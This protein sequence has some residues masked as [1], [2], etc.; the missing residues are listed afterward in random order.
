M[1]LKLLLSCLWMF[2]ITSVF[3]KQIDEKTALQIGRNFLSANASSQ[4]LKSASNLRVTYRLTSNSIATNSQ[5]TLYYVLK[6]GSSGF[7]IV[8]GDDNVSPIL[9]YSDEGAF[10][11]DSIPANAAKWFEGY[12]N[13]I[14]Y[15]IANNIDASPEIQEEWQALQSGVSIKSQALVSLVSPL[16][17]T[18]WN[19]SPY[20][21]AM[22]PGGSVTGCVATA[23]AQ[24]MKYWQYPEKG[25]GF[26]SYRHQRYGTLSAN[27]GS[28]TYQWGS[29]PNKVTSSNNAVA[30][31]MYQVG[32]SVDMEYSPEESGAYVIS[33]SSP[34]TNCSEYAFKTYFGYKN[35][36]KGISR[37]D[38]T[39]TQWLNILKTEL[40][41]GR[42]VLYDGCGNGGGHCFVA[43]GYDNNNYIHFN[44]GWG[45]AYDGYFRV[46]AL[47]PEGTGTGGGTGGYNSYQEAIIGIEPAS[48][49]G[50][51]PQ[52]DGLALYSDLKMSSSEIFFWDAFD[53][54][55]DVANY[56]T[57]RFTGQLG[58]AVFDKNYNFVDFIETTTDIILDANYYYNLTFSNLGTAVFVPGTYYAAIFYKTGTQD[59]T[60]VADGDYTNLTQFEIYYS[61]DIE[62]NSAFNIT[63]NNGKLI[64]G[65]SITVN[66]DALN[67]GSSTFN[68]NL[69]LSLASLDGNWVQ[70]IQI[71]NESKGLKPNYHYTSGIN[72]TGTITVEPG[73]YLLE[74]GFQYNGSSSWYYAGSSSYSNPVY[75]IVEAPT[76]LA[77]AYESND[78]QSKAYSLPVVFSNNKATIST[79]GSNCHITSDN[80]F[81]K[82]VLPSGYHYTITPQLNDSY[83]SND[84]NK[85][86]LDG[87]FSYSTD[88]STWSDTYDDVMPEN[89]EMTNGGTVYFHVVPYF[90]GQTGTYLLSM[91]ATR[92]LTNA[93]VENE[94]G[95]TV[96]VYPNPAKDYV[97]V[98]LN[99]SV[100]SPYAIEIESVQGQNVLYESVKGT[101]QPHRI[102]LEKLNKG[103]YFINIQTTKGMLTN[104]LIISK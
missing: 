29:M 14:R 98:D 83:K 78:T 95:A 4:N 3:A 97:M 96:K 23:M 12:K 54:N 42:P 55:V 10:N 90:A 81:Y 18:K 75:V 25:S 100:A 77:D 52:S 74:M 67:T 101:G 40:D 99:E 26:Y 34:I 41:A 64:Q 33:S 58:A 15:V 53:L 85:Y 63:S 76:I 16:I 37:G 71:Y 22:C 62:V 8:A 61:A 30:T 21:N 66:V 46:N 60:I 2:I 89:I 6:A 47:N 35:T 36:L 7:V 51:T 9:G 94:S 59:W 72:F 44:W 91:D 50:T 68:G 103:I 13:E 84:G 27:F 24:I 57:G 11:P 31:L 88:G 19:Q 87:L 43:D 93:I 45:G 65:N 32:V 73:T 49:G 28:T 82:V 79:P 56:G 86:T 80:D 5:T 70:N 92:S 17:S 48:N 69:R 1:K 20:Y 102:P 38:Y 104:K 39:Q